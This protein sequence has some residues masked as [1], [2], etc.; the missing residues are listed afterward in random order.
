MTRIYGN[1]KY[2]Q[3]FFKIEQDNNNMQQNSLWLIKSVN[4]S[5]FTKSNSLTF[6][7]FDK[8]LYHCLMSVINLLIFLS[9]NFHVI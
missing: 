9:H 5:T 8:I 2:I 4:N 7:I 3:P 6:I 1:Q